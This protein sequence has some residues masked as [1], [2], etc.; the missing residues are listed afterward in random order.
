MLVSNSTGPLSTD[1]AFM[2]VADVPTLS[3][4]GLID[5]PTNPFTGTILSNKLKEATLTTN[6]YIC[7]SRMDIPNPELVTKFPLM[8]IWEI[9]PSDVLDTSNYKYIGR[10]NLKGNCRF[11]FR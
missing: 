7:L 1:D 6:N 10:K 5:D 2:T 8:D 3:T 11:C 9:T 4:Q